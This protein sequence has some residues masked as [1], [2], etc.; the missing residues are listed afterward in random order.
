MGQ[1]GWIAEGGTS[2]V[3]TGVSSARHYAMAA[4]EK[5]VS[6][7]C[8][9]IEDVLNRLAQVGEHVREQ[10]RFPDLELLETSGEFVYFDPWAEAGCP[11]ASPVQAY[12][13]LATGGKREQEAAEQ[14]KAVIWRCIG[15]FPGEK[16]L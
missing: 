7:Y 5:T 2:I 14:T 13:E 9:D 3:V 4:L 6:V 11:W 1:A 10:D 12:L 15:Y 16:A 8:S